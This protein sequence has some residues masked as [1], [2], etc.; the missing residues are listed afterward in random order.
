MGNY[1]FTTK[2]LVEALQRD[3]EDEDSVHDIGGSIL[4]QLT[5]RGEA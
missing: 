2:A 4:P 1:V 3:A 5:D